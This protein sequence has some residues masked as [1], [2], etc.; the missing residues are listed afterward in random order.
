MEANHWIG[1]ANNA[2]ACTLHLS[3]QMCVKTRILF[4]YFINGIDGIGTFGNAE[5]YN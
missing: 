1:M 5:K 4:G 3:I 2:I